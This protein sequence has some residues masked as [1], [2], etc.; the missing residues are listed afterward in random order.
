MKGDELCRRLA[1]LPETSAIPI[2]LMSSSA[3]EISGLA[4]QQTNIVRM[5]VKPFSCELLV[6][7]VSYVLSHWEQRQQAEQAASAVGSIV[8]R[9]NTLASPICNALRFIEQRQ[10]T[11]VLRINISGV[12]LHTFCKE[13][14]V[15]VVSTRHFEDYLDG[16]PFL[17][18]G[19]KSPIWKRCE[20]RQ[21]ETLS[22]FILN[23]NLE[24]VLPLQTA[25]ILTNVY[26]HRL[27]A[28]VW[29]EK[30][31][32]YEFEQTPL[33]DFVES[34]QSPSLRINDWILENLRNV[35][36]ADEIQ[37]ILGDPNGIPTFTPS[38]YTQI[39][40]VEPDRD[41]LK[42]LS[43]ITG[44]TPFSEICR[45]TRVIPNL[46]ARRIFYYQRLGFIDY[47]PSNV[48]QAHG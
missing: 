38:G 28:R 21:L 10:L 43:H 46:A 48:L 41:E 12:T 35:Q 14:A 33:P 39:R 45:Q 18:H 24:G 1:H 25:Q 2:I 40:D 27:F 5:L 17:T 36:E 19:K 47:W 37:L 3:N 4:L 6:A 9:G 11:G 34:C 8:I 13:G 32:N 29:T 42:I 22:P 16:T 44:A 7:T 30:N 15:R 23:L 31:A 20:E 26:G